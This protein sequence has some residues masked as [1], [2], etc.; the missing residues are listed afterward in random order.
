MVEDLAG[1]V[2]LVP[3]PDATDAKDQASWNAMR[4]ALDKSSDKVQ[5]TF[6][7]RRASAARER[8]FPPPMIKKVNF[9]SAA[10]TMPFP[11]LDQ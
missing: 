1:L 7:V 10:N 5:R 3:E 8:Q 6:N 9:C 4:A 2:A 11:T